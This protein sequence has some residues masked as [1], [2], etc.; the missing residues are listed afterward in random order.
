MCLVSDNII[1]GNCEWAEVHIAPMGL[2]ALSLED[3][4]VMDGGRY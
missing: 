3:V 4:V 1:T 2:C